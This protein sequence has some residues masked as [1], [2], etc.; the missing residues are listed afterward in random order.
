MRAGG[1]KR[2]F[3]DYFPAQGAQFPRFFGSG[4][5]QFFVENAAI[6]GECGRGWAVF[7]LARLPERRELDFGSC[8]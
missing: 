7:R 6:E 1:M 3:S 8:T 4:G 2:K 5:K